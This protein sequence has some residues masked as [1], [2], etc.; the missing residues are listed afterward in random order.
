[1]KNQ[2][3]F[4]SIVAVVVTLGVFFIFFFGM[5]KPR[6]QSEVQR[7]KHVDVAVVTRAV[8]VAVVNPVVVADKGVAVNAVAVVE[9]LVDD[10]V[11]TV[12]V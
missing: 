7:V 8:D 12:V 9:T 5:I 6:F 4:F 3:F 2:K 10:Q 1:M 11:A